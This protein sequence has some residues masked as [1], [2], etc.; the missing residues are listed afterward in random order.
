[1]DSFHGCFYFCPFGL[2]RLSSFPGKVLVEVY[3][4]FINI[5]Y[6]W[7]PKMQKKNIRP[8]SEGQLLALQLLQE[9]SDWVSNC[10]WLSFGEILFEF[11]SK[12][13]KFWW[14][15]SLSSKIVSQGS[16]PLETASDGEA[17]GSVGQPSLGSCLPCLT[18][19]NY[20]THLITLSP[21]HSGPIWVCVLVFMDNPYSASHSGG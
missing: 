15:T 8:E 12:L 5:P 3:T 21:D 1:M 6:S 7:R 2:H 14:S 20:H 19:R 11:W 13:V 18:C 10:F 17:G 4:G 16:R 9:L